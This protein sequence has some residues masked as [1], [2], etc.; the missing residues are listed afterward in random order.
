MS[1]PRGR[2]PVSHPRTVRRVRRLRR[3]ACLNQFFWVAVLP[4][5]GCGAGAVIGLIGTIMHWRTP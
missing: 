3:A 4:F 1:N 5:A 2:H